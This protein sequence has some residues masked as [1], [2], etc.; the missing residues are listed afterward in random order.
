MIRKISFMLA[1]ALTVS[2]SAFAQSPAS[3]GAP[4]KIGVI[5]IQAA[6]VSTTEGKR[7]FDAL[8]KK[9]EPKRQEINRGTEELDA[10]K[11][12]LNASQDKLSEEERATR[13]RVIETKQ[14]TLQRTVEDAQNDFQGQQNEMAQRV[15][16][17]LLDVL[18]KYARANGYSVILDISSQQS[19]VLW[20]GETVNITQQI[21]DAYNAQP[22]G[23][24]A[25]P[26]GAAA[27][28]PRKPAAAATPK[29]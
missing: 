26:A 6:I 7:D 24:P 15:G 23:A 18:D 21:V 11:K 12:Q 10:L 25:R 14:K 8:E 22:G 13:L 17:K 3:A 27:T 19:P 28:P 29:K 9:F 5:H 20:A 4:N 16:G 1:A 2:A